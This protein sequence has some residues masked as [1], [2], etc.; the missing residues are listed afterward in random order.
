[1]R[2]TSWIR[3]CGLVLAVLTLIVSMPELA[4]AQQAGLFP[5]APIKRQRVPCD[6][7]DPVYKVYK[8]K[9]F[10]YHPSCWRPF[11]SGWGCPSP[12]KPDVEKAFRELK[13]GAGLNPTTG[14]PE[15][16]QQ[17]DQPSG[18]PELP[19]LP[20]GARSPFD[21]PV[22]PGGDR[23]ANPATP[24]QGESPFNAPAAPPANNPG[25]ASTA[26]RPGRAQPASPLTGEGTPELTAPEQPARLEGTQ[27]SRSPRDDDGP[28][29]SVGD[30]TVP[31][32]SDADDAFG[33][34]PASSGTTT[35]DATPAQA[36]PASSPPRR[37]FLSGLFNNLGWNWTRR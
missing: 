37:G 5:L 10:G 25:A 34:G 31:P 19:P 3:G 8:E 18:R 9:Y 28:L 20:A 12:E 11:P 21:Q 22:P 4:R 33:A 6:Q 2:T 14:E 17:G 15:E 7:E 29:L 27:T 13:L 1:M 16:M 32:V 30:I 26:P 35:A 23:P 24:R 36:A